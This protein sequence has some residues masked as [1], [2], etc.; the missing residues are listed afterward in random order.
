MNKASRKI[1]KKCIFSLSQVQDIGHLEL[2]IL[3]IYF[4]IHNSIHEFSLK[5]EDSLIISHA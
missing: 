4:S 3:P 1:T 2:I 5:L